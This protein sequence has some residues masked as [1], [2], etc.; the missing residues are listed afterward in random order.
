M[1]HVLQC[2]AQGA[3]EYNPAKSGAEWWV[4]FRGPDHTFGE[5]I[6][7]HWDRDEILADRTGINIHPQV[8][9]DDLVCM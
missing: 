2:L 4:H 9:A 6:G 5:S 7:F 1:C 3:E 8:C